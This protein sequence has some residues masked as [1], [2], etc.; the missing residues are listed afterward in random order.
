M[1]RDAAIPQQ[2]YEVNIPPIIPLNTCIGICLE[3]CVL[4]D[5]KYTDLK[6]IRHGVL[7]DID[8]WEFEM[9]PWFTS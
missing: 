2:V 5:R 1:S 8:I 4:V 6:N 7:E 9:Q 3:N